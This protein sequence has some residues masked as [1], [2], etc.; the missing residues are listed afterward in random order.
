MGGGGGVE[1]RGKRKSSPKPYIS[2][3]TESCCLTEPRAL[4]K[5]PGG[6]WWVM[7]GRWVVLESHFSVQPKLSQAEQY[8]VN[9]QQRIIHIY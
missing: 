2:L 4:K 5:V 8:I 1:D 7:G 9:Y 3:H 6:G